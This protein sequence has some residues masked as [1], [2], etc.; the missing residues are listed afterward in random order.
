M[1]RSSF[2]VLLGFLAPVGIALAADGW[3]REYAQGIVSTDS[4]V[5]YNAVTAV[6]PNSS[7]GRAALFDVLEKQTWHVRNG[8]IDRLATATGEAL[9]ELKKALEK[10]GSPFV[11]EG[12]TLAFA[13]TRDNV[14]FA[15]PIA[16][17]C[18]KLRHCG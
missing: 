2:V 3:E 16:R 9:D 15:I 11:L 10:N 8:A 12:I 14:N 1:R 18:A 5:R 7:K 6:D 4:N 13:K 17:V